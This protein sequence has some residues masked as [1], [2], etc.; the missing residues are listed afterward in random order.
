MKKNRIL[1][2]L[3]CLSLAAGLVIPGLPAYAE[4]EGES[5][6]SGM[7]LSKTAVAND[8]GTYTITLEAYATGEKVISQ[9]N[10]DV[11]T[12][13]VLV[14]DQ[15]GSMGTKD[16][17]SVGEPTYTA[18]TGNQ[19][20]N[21]NLYSK[22]HNNNGSNGNLYY[23][24]DD[25]SY[26]TV[27]VVRTRENSYTYTQCPSDWKNYTYSS[28]D[29]DYLKYF[30]NLYVKNE[31][32]VYKKVTVTYENTAE[33]YEPAHYV[34]TYTFPNGKVV[35]SEGN[36]GQPG[37]NNFDGN[38]PVYYLSSTT[39]G[40]YTYTYTCTDAEGKTI[41]IG[42]STG[43]DTNFTDAPL[44]YR[45]DTNGSN[46]SR[47]E[48]LINAV[49]AF[50]NSVANKA[51]G[52][53]GQLGTAD[54]IDH[55]I[56]VVG[57]A[58]GDPSD[59][60]YLNSEVFVGAGQYQYN[61]TASA[62][63][64]EAFQSMKTEKG[65]N[66]IKASINA[67]TANGATYTNL[68]VE[69]ANGILQANPVP[70]GEKRNRVVIVF[71]DGVPGR[72]GYS[73]TVAESAITQANTSR[74]LGASVYA[75][76]IFEGADATS[77]GNQNGNNTQKANWFMQNLSNN[78]GTPQ[79][80]SYYLSAANSNTL[81]NIFQQIASNIET[82]GSSTTLDANAVIRDIIAPQFELPANATTESIKLYTA[83]SNGSVNSWETRETFAGSVSLGA[84]DNS[85]SV[86]G[87]SF[88]DNW[89]GNQTINGQ[90]TFHDGKKL[91]IEFTVQPK[92][93][94]LGGNDVYTNTSAGIY[95][96]GSA[97][98]PL[99]TFDRPTVNVPIKEV[100]V[101]AADKD[102]YLLGTVTAAQLQEGADVKVGD[103]SLDLSADNYGLESWQ[104]E[105]VDITVEIKDEKGNV[106]SSDLSDLIDDTTYTVTVTV[107]PK[108]AD[109][110]SDGTPATEQKG[111]GTANINVYKPEL[112]Y[113]DSEVFYGDAVPT[114]FDTN[115]RIAPTKWKH[116]TSEATADMGTAPDLAITYKPEA[117][118]IDE[119][120]KIASTEDIQV[121]ATVKIG[122][123]D[124]TDKT[125]F[126][127]NPCDPACG[128]NETSQG[129]SPAFLLHVKTATLKIT[130]AGNVGATEGF[131][132]N[133]SGPQSFR[134][135]VQG[136]G[137]VTITGLPLGTYTVTEETDWSWRYKN[138]VSI[139]AS[140]V[141][142]TDS[143]Y[144]AEVTVTNTRT[145]E[146]LL[147]GNDY[148][149]NNSALLSAGN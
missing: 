7:K 82:G 124:V 75:V 3:L 83:E 72:T 114:D 47:L 15:S 41:E 50:T 107:T 23:Q 6:S 67:L 147:D 136:N 81:N 30:E 54:D 56:A 119:N 87:F 24:L 35:T 46:I 84:N 53:D 88:K 123:T 1:S 104:N 122:D 113:K 29:D 69:M 70:N 64:S 11:P 51:K 120:N 61:T 109:A 28:R 48:A 111:S 9:V 16:F 99:L 49:T 80:P 5:S 78:K 38:G 21:S 32:G 112:T 14:L 145:N 94:F 34:Y 65:Q 131:I 141:T 143:D 149:Q 95:E 52:A 128:W 10:K 98:N 31:A 74:T 125:T 85:V 148:A 142:L 71:T 132:F 121:A 22:R 19:T 106:I 13:I 97:E 66:N 117:S 105:Y 126:V 45:T 27:S 100:T 127:H 12:D 63:Y 110:N 36:D 146:Y 118:K 42:T 138:G 59:T 57:F 77:A 40:E 129:G 91:I 26:A 90:E 96:N 137:S 62:H 17:P 2:A 133:V 8:N 44:Y 60:L 79:T 18:Y 4:G 73:S 144:T 93:G 86:S 102:V 101:T 116:G 108:P 68:G 135:S 25:G 55:R 140:S 139:S 37:K 39:A 115:N 43:A 134:V 58:S 20:R 103:V 92:A 33:W 130:K 76:G 89:C